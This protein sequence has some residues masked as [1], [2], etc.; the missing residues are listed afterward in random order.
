MSDP[1]F[2][3]PAPLPHAC[4]L[5]YGKREDPI[6]ALWDFWPPSGRHPTEK[7]SVY[8]SARPSDATFRKDLFYMKKGKLKK[9]Q[10]ENEKL[11][12]KW[13]KDKQSR[14]KNF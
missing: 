1:T 13:V 6:P 10:A 9:A 5:P 3:C 7:L 8:I 12:K 14:A 11:F 4:A 2:G